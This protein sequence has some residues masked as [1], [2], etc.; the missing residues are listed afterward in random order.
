[1][2]DFLGLTKCGDTESKDSY[3][4]QLMLDL[5][6]IWLISEFAPRKEKRPGYI[7]PG[8]SVVSDLV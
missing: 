3:R 8:L 1:M 7:T 6:R 5:A 4:G 2:L